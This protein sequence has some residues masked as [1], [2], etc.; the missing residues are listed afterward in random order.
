MIY[1]NHLSW[2]GVGP[3]MPLR[4][5]LVCCSAVLLGAVLLML[6]C[7]SSSPPDRLTIYVR[8]HQSSDV[9]HADTCAPVNEVYVDERGI[10]K[11]ALCPLANHTVDVEIVDGARH[12]KVPSPDVHIRRTGDG[13]ATSVEA[14]PAH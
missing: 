13:I 2:P 1:S 14:R 10:G 7:A 3:R 12:Y 11:T 5:N 4:S 8:A 9:L 6:S